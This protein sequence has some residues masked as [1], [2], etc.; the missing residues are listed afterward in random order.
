[1][2][3]VSL[4]TQTV[5]VTN[6]QLLSPKDA[7]SDSVPPPSIL[8]CDT[9]RPR[10]TLDILPPLNN[11]PNSDS[12]SSQIELKC[13]FAVHGGYYDHDKLAICTVN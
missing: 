12:M 7:I 9:S 2:K 4:P 8:P 1:M 3:K 11:S 13:D 6:T 5:K 10:K